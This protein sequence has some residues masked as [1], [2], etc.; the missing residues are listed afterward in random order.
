MGSFLNDQDEYIY[1]YFLLSCLG[2]IISL[3]EFNYLKSDLS[4]IWGIIKHTQNIT[5]HLPITY[6]MYV[7]IVHIGSVLSIIPFNIWFYWYVD[8]NI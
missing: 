5:D 1:N 7:S 2:H 8:T 3:S 4:S 6:G